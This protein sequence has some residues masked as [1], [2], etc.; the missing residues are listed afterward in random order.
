MNEEGMRCEISQEIGHF[1]PNT[2][3]PLKF[4]VFSL[5]NI[6]LKWEVDLYPGAWATF[7]QFRDLNS[8]VL[9]NS[10]KILKE[11]FYTYEDEDLKLYEFWDYFGKYNKDST[12]LILGSGN[13]LWGEWVL[14]IHRNGISC[15]LV[16]GSSLI[17]NELT[18]NYKGMENTFT[19][20]SDIISP[21][22]EDWDFYDLGGMGDSTLN[23]EYMKKLSPSV[24]LGIPEK[25]PTTSLNDLLKKFHE[26]SWIRIDLEGIDK[27]LILSLNEENLKNLK[28]IQYECLFMKEE[29]I[30]EVESFLKANNFNKKIIF[31]I[32]V[33]YF[34]ESIF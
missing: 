33:V 1:L 4:Q 32:D 24:F 14:P 34:K 25:N 21:D 8:R 3:F 23:P 31:D 30:E 19:L 7:P 13:G 9:T 18:K 6:N 15:H 16:E 2:E 26:I 28:M 27:D 12:G 22:G 20:H 11:Y 29:E 17:F 10:G 5:L